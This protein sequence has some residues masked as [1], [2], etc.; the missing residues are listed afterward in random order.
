MTSYIRIAVLVGAS[1]L[2]G[3][4]STFKHT[5]KNPDATA[6]EFR[7]E[8]V[9]AIVLVKD[10]STRRLAE[11]RLAQQIAAHG[12][13]GR[14]MYSIAPNATV[15]NEQETRA[16]LEKQGVKGV[17]VMRPISI[18][19]TVHITPAEEEA[20]YASFWGGYYGY[21][22]SVAYTSGSEEKVSE[23]YVA[24]VETL[25]YSLKQNNLGCSGQSKT[26][27]LDTVTELIEELVGA[28]VTELKKE[29]LVK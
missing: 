25:V 23:S 19:R 24:Y 15:G 7:G 22:Y 5:W 20:T 8:K 21:G 3:C 10:E 17:V 27:K 9:V 1:L 29:G 16:I 14:T 26:T 11:N 4:A 28:T 2:A 13:Q 18:D 12:A 6:L